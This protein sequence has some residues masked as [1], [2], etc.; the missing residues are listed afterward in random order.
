[1]NCSSPALLCILILFLFP[2]QNTLTKKQLGGERNLLY[3]K[4]PDYTHHWGEVKA[5][6]RIVNQ[7]RSQEQKERAL[8]VLTRLLVVSFI[9]PPTG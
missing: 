9:P 2:W 1:M 4:I 6:T 7:I 8:Y 3:L 5:E